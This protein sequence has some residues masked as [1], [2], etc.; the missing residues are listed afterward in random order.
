M[1]FRAFDCLGQII[2]RGDRFGL[3]PEQ[4]LDRMGIVAF[5]EGDTPR[6]VQDGQISTLLARRHPQLA[7]ALDAGRKVDLWFQEMPDPMAAAFTAQ[8]FYDRMPLAWQPRRGR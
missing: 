8:E 5:F 2:R 7:E 6:F 1:R 3:E 4:P